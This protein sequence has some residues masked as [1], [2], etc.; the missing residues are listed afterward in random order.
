MVRKIKA[1]AILRPNDQGLSGRDDSQISGN[2]EVERGRGAVRL[3]HRG[4][5]L[6]GRGVLLQFFLS[7]WGR[8][9]L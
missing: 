9:R 3:D 7:N 1:K 2:R 8:C 6:S 5:R 4:N